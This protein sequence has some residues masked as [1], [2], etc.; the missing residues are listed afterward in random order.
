VL[1]VLK[2]WQ[3]LC[4]RTN[5]A[6]KHSESKLSK[7]QTHSKKQTELSLAWSSSGDNIKYS[8][9]CHRFGLFLIPQHTSVI[10]FCLTLVNF[11]FIK[12]HKQLYN[13]SVIGNITTSTR[14]YCSM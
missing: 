10:R 2:W 11:I 12:W 13:R 1:I 7:C 3:C 5:F 9:G 14:I 6:Q 8:F 4:T